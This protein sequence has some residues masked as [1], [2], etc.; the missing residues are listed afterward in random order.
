MNVKEIIPILLSRRILYTKRGREK[1][2]ISSIVIKS[3]NT[4]IVFRDSSFS[5]PSLFSL[6]FETRPPVITEDI[7]DRE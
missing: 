2:K 4:R 7:D 5:S 1:R 3:E 6:F